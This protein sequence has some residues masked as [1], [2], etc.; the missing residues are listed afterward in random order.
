MEN[1]T[2]TPDKNVF[3]IM[4]GGTGGHIFPGLAVA[5]ELKK[6]GYIIHWLGTSQGMEA[7]L[8]PKHNLPISF[9]SIKGIRGK[10]LRALLLA[11]WLILASTLQAIRIMRKLKP[12]GALGMGGFVAGPGSF[13][14]R[15]LGIPLVIHEQNAISGITNRIA[16]PM[17]KKVLTAFPGVF[18]SSEKVVVT[19][20]PVRHDLLAAASVDAEERTD[21]SKTDNIKK[22]G[23]LNLLV[24]G[25]SRGALAINKTVPA[26]LAHMNTAVNVWHQTG[27][28]HQK[29]TEDCYARHNGSRRVE[30][31]IDD[32]TAAYRWADLIICRSGALT[33]AELAM[34][35]KPSILIPY[36]WHKD[37]QQLRNAEFLAQHEAAIIIEQKV[38]TAEYLATKIAELETNRSLLIKMGISA[39]QCAMPG[40][41]VKIA[42]ICEDILDE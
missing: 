24:L 10:G 33:V 3:M 35:E 12:V 36:P 6:R 21:I 41:T 40:A 13:A 22:T 8:I 7:A 4:A 38:L 9:L 28:G 5:E 42:Q 25:G 16:A 26:A 39:R 17:A 32:M 15:I 14:A 19:G 27:S 34:V 23:E 18:A 37:Q 20:N 1:L 31:F 30:E 11:P 2:T 29:D